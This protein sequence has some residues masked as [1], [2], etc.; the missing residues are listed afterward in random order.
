M[1]AKSRPNAPRQPAECLQK[2]CKM[3]DREHARARARASA[4]ARAGTTGNRPPK[5]SKIHTHI[6]HNGLRLITQKINLLG[7]N[8]VLPGNRLPIPDMPGNAKSCSRDVLPCLCLKKIVTISV[9]VCKK[10]KIVKNALDFPK[11]S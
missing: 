3:P 7:T 2:P 8:R 4:R 5:S 6:S 10:N 11:N 9:D 1:C